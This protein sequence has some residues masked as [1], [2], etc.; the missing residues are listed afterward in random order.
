MVCVVEDWMKQSDD[1]HDFDDDD[2]RRIEQKGVQM[3]DRLLS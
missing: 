1:H 2:Q 3:L